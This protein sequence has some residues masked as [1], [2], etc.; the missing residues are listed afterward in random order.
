MKITD[1]RQPIPT[2]Y[3]GML[4]KHDT[5]WKQQIQTL[6]EKFGSAVQEVF[7]PGVD[8]VDVP[9][10]VVKVESIIDVLSFVKNDSGY[11]YNFLSD[12]TAVDH[13][14]TEPRF[15]VVYNL[16]SWTTLAR[17]RIKV[18]VKEGEEVPTAISVWNGANWAEREVWDMFGIRFSGHPD[19]RRI[20]M[21]HRWEGHPLR[22]DYPLRGYQI[23]PT[24]E[25]IDLELLK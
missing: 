11:S 4:K 12:L 23:F 24:A 18:R 13:H 2:N 9:V 22:K 15:E 1:I 10:V 14:P 5:S 6:K 20:L 17:F 16:F 8:T 3:G 25:P 21:D 7:Y 19:L